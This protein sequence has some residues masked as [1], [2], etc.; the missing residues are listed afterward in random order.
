MRPSTC[1]QTTV[2]SS[3]FGPA[4]IR[5][6][7]AQKVHQARAPRTHTLAFTTEARMLDWNYW[8]EIF[9]ARVPQLVTHRQRP[10]DRLTD[11][12]RERIAASIATFQLGEQ[13]EGRTLLRFAE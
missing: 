12:D 2:V 7:L 3:S 5:P 10:A 4:T 11:D 13:S 9:E 8:L 1:A 6:N